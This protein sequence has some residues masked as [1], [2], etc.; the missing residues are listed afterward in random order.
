VKKS[1]LVVLDRSRV[2]LYNTIW[3]IGEKK[4]YISIPKEKI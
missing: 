4:H 2:A 3:Q 1:R